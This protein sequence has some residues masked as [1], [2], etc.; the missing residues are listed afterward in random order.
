MAHL[1]DPWFRNG[2]SRPRVLETVTEWQNC[3]SLRKLTARHRSRYVEI[4][5][6]TQMVLSDNPQL[7][8]YNILK[9]A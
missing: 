8:N 4:R 7:N 6:F 9:S 2:S 5:E 1:T 3:A